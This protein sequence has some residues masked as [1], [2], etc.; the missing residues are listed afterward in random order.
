MTEAPGRSG[1]G[2]LGQA[3]WGTGRQQSVCRAAGVALIGKDI[4]VI[5]IIFKQVTA[6]RTACQ[7]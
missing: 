5:I 1:S 3:S 7:L 6:S 4:V 2:S